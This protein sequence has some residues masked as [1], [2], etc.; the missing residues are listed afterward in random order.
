MR[1]Y[2]SQHVTTRA[3]CECEFYE[4][5]LEMTSSAG[6]FSQLVVATAIHNATKQI[7]YGLHGTIDEVG[8]SCLYKYSLE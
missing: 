1:K 2:E 4:E 6:V 5:I 7:I 8:S 3:E